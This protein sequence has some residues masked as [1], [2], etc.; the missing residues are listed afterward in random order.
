MKQFFRRLSPYLE[1]INPII[2][3]LLA[4]AASLRLVD[5][6]RTGHLFSLDAASVAY[7][8]AFGF[9]LAGKSQWSLWRQRKDRET[10]ANPRSLP[11]EK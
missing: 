10:A 6:G 9:F 7:L 4:G 8:G 3:A 2:G 5:Y 1:F 11:S